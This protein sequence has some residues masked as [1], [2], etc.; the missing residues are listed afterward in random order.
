MSKL[1][2]PIEVPQVSNSSLSPNS[3]S[4]GRTDSQGPTDGRHF[5]CTPC[6]DEDEDPKNTNPSPNPS[7][8]PKSKKMVSRSHNPK[9][10]S[11]EPKSDRSGNPSCA[12]ITPITSK[13]FLIETKLILSGTIEHLQGRCGMCS[14]AVATG[15]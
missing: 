12:R 1:P 6:V 13:L 15:G 14:V 5:W 8:Q 10:N 11:P 9:P 3:I 7:S 2:R 4:A